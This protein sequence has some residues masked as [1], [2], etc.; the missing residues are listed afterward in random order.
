M[1]GGGQS[2]TNGS[3]SGFLADQIYI[4]FLGVSTGVTP[5]TLDS[6]TAAADGSGVLLKWHSISE[7][8]NAGYNV[9]RRATGTEE[10]SPVNTTLIAGRITNADEHTYR[11]FDWAPNGRYEYRLE[12]LSID[13]AREDYASLAGPVTV[14]NSVA[15]DSMSDEDIDAA[16]AASEAIASAGHVREIAAQFA[17][18]NDGAQSQKAVAREM[19]A[20]APR[21]AAP[22]PPLSDL[23]TSVAARWFASASPAAKSYTAAKVLYVQPGVLAIPQAALPAGFD[24]RHVTI[25][26]EGRALP[27]LAEQNNTLYVYAPG[28]STT[29]TPTK[30]RS[31]SAARPRPRRPA[32][33]HSP[34]D[35]SAASPRTRTAPRR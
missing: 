19:A 32:P 18:L 7:F 13:G 33:S 14:D 8:Q 30:T 2:L 22:V 23:N 4:V 20:G 34:A 25:Q 11:L 35:C 12:S 31:S 28:Y 6:F 10:W 24:T 16:G 15:M 21:A 26:R 1:L 5:A 29:I 17:A 27:I 3:G 9:Y